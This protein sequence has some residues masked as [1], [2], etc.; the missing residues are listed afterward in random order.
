M[1]IKNINMQLLKYVIDHGFSK[2]EYSHKSYFTL[3]ILCV[4]GVQ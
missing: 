1:L 3:I 2:F 4:Y